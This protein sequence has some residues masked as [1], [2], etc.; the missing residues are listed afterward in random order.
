MD[1]LMRQNEVIAALER[2]KSELEDI[3]GRFQKTRDGIHIQ[4]GDRARLEVMVLELRDFF[5]EEFENGRRHSQ[6]VIS[7][8]NSGLSNFLMSPSLR[9][10]EQIKSVVEST[11]A[12][13]R[14]NPLSIK[15]AAIEARAKGIKD[16]DGVVR[17]A[18]RLHLVVCQLRQRREERP[19]LNVADEYD[20]QDLMHALLKIYF[21]DVRTEEW[22]PSC[23]G[24]ASRMDF[25]LP[26]IESVIEIKRTRPNLPTKHLGEQLIIDIAKYR[27]HRS[28]RSLFCIVYDPEGRIVNPRGVEND[29]STTDNEMTTLVM[30]VPRQQPTMSARNASGRLVP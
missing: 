19:T 3:L 13:A 15:A 22:T 24:G 11:L 5:D 23:A 14:R 17:L 6:P 2:Y 16:A 28:C 12:R 20:V 26:E 7:A 4:E 10:V 21:D 1:L 29:L 30:I 25:I 18:E 8:Y 9:S 27:K